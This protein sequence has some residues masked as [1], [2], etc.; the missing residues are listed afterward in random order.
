MFKIR[1]LI[2]IVSL[3]FLAGV[4]L[5]ANSIRQHYIVPIIMYHYVHPNPDSKDRLTVSP[6]TFE[7]QMR[8]LKEKRYNVIPLEELATLIKDKKKI[9]PKTIVITTDDGHKD[10]YDYI[11]P[12][13]RK[14]N[15]PAT[16]FVIIDEIGRPQ[17]DR[18]SWDEIKEMQDSGIIS[19]G[20]HSLGPEP[21]INIKS[22]EEI[23]RQV[24]ESKRILEEK[25]GKEVSAFSYPEGF[26]N[27]KIKKMVMDAGYK[28]SVATSPGI[29]F[30]D[31]D[32]FALKRLRI[33]SNAGNLFIFYIEASGYYL[34]V[35]EFQRRNR[36]R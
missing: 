19:I 10:N 35:R 7:R 4:L 11:F 9:P 30:P 33:S 3:I 15:L 34:P 2:I 16:M 12:I 27:A 21:L 28:A 36:D 23:K 25:S 6:V 13:L 18:L 26:F 8:F 14:Y 31:N 17:N 22:E 24:F 32:P 29:N 1:K 5:L 20:S